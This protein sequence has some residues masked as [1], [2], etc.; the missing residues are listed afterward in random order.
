MGLSEQWACMKTLVV[1][2]HVEQ[3]SVEKICPFTSAVRIAEMDEGAAVRL[4]MS[5]LFYQTKIY[6]APNL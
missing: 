3:T 6:C 5:G 4:T 1:A 2:P